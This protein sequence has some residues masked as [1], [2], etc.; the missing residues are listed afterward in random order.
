MGIHLHI[1]LGNA[2][3]EDGMRL[4]ELHRIV[5]AAADKLSSQG[6]DFSVYDING[7]KVGRLD[8][9]EHAPIVEGH[10]VILS[11]NELG[12]AA[13]IDD[14]SLGDASVRDAECARILRDAAEK[15]G[16]GQSEFSLRDSNGNR[17][18]SYAEVGEEPDED[19]EASDEEPD[20]EQSVEAVSAAVPYTT[21]PLP[22]DTLHFKNGSAWTVVEEERTTSAGASN[23]S[24]VV[25]LL[26]DP[27]DADVHIFLPASEVATRVAAL[28]RTLEYVIDMDERGEFAA[29][30]RQ[31]DEKT[32]FE[33]H[34]SEIFEDGFMANK[35]DLA[36]LTEYLR[37]IKVIGAR[38]VILATNEF[39]HRMETIIEQASAAQESW[40]KSLTTTY[41]GTITATEEQKSLLQS[42]GVTVGGPADKPGDLIVRLTQEAHEAFEGFREEFASELLPITDYHKEWAVEDMDEATLAGYVAFAKF[43]TFGGEALPAELAAGELAAAEAE[44]R[45][46]QAGK[47]ASA[48]DTRPSDDSIEP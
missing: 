10:H 42:I 36:G 7:N 46:R 48:T 45:V 12:N 33:I 41:Y 16:S 39:Q 13:F 21:T 43:A 17:V 32:I 25:H 19:H 8:E 2:A 20:E 9:A 47:G 15:I 4:H 38:D 31:S 35:H 23:Q 29:D 24:E 1:Q 44:L 27:D 40:R 11:I 34:G 6:P 37:D 18:G 3:F 26:I 28:T 30:V 5:R 14:E 22:G